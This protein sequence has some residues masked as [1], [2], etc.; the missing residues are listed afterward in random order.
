MLYQKDVPHIINLKLVQAAYAWW[1]QLF[2]VI[3]D[4]TDE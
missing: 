3:D 1:P 2:A 4:D